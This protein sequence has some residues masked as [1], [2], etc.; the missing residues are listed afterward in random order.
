M[1]P[2]IDWWTWHHEPATKTIWLQDHFGSFDYRFR[3]YFLDLIPDGY[4]VYSEYQFPEEVH[5]AYPQLQLKFSAWLWLYA[6]RIWPISDT[7]NLLARPS[8][9]RQT[10]L[11]AFFRSNQPERHGIMAMLNDRGWFNPDF[12]SKHFELDPEQ[13]I[14]LGIEYDQVDPNFATT[15]VKHDFVSPGDHVH[16]LQTLSEIIQSSFVHFV[17]ETKAWDTTV[18]FPTEKFLYAVANRTLWLA[19]APPNY[20]KMINQQFGFRLHSCFD[21]FFDSR[22][23]Q[24][25]RLSLLLEQFQQFSKY[26]PAQWQQIYAAEQDT[27]EY[28]YQRLASMEF[29]DHVVRSD[30]ELGITPE[31]PNK[32]YTSTCK[33]VLDRYQQIK[34]SVGSN[35]AK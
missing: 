28:N 32:R 6:N 1:D 25:D 22:W 18:C 13:L 33:P 17:V 24:R 34:A 26:T 30:Q 16:N 27:L 31:P 35:L 20:H 11:S 23:E 4:T 19:T 3:N 8:N 29:F 9:R 7:A 14:R 10:F 12:C 15:I 21:Y 2:E 5:R